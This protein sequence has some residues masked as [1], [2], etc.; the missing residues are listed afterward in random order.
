MMNLRA[1]EISKIFGLFLKR[2]T[3]PN[4]IKGDDDAMRAEMNSLLAV[5][6]RFAPHQ[7][8]T[9]WV[10]AVLDDLEYSME[11]RAWPTK[12]QLGR[13]C[14]E[15]SKRQGV[16]R[17]EEY[18]VDP[19]REN[20]RRIQARE[21]VGDEWIYGRR[22]VELLASGLVTRGDIEAYRKGMAYDAKQIWGDDVAGSALARME[23]RHSAAEQLYG[24][25]QRRDIK[26]PAIRRMEAA[27]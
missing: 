19:I 8:Y 20:A 14:K 22:A 6:V 2:Y 15:R 25:M 18:K 27:E 5:L 13:A 10:S 9:D 7:G 3:P 21:L 26:A 16:G 12:S 4:G 11:T 1:V 24:D 17:G 23:A